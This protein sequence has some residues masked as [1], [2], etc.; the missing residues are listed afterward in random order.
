MSQ[1]QG[2]VRA[3]LAAPRILQLFKWLVGGRSGLSAFV[4]EYVRPRPGDNLLDIGC[5]IGDVVEH[6]PEVNYTGFD[7]SAEYILS[8]RQRYGNRGRFFCERVDVAHCEEGAYDLVLSIGVLHHL[9]D[10]EALNLF[11]LAAHALKP[12]GRLITLDGCFTPD[13]S[14]LARFIISRDRGQNVRTEEGYRRL[15][16]QI[17]SLRLLAVHIRHNL[18]RT[19]YTHIILECE[20]Y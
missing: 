15:A 11:R 2:G 8:A 19:P 20:K 16:T 7:T 5:G 1:V 3:I 9:D 18:L 6:L 12:G 4:N 17:C 14:R 13:Q 10:P